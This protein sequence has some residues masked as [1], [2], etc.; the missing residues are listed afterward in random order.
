MARIGNNALLSK[1]LSGE[2]EP[3]LGP[4]PITGWYGTDE[5]SENCCVCCQD[6]WDSLIWGNNR[7]LM[8]DQAIRHICKASVNFR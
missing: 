8:Y 6:L 3:A 2:D 5:Q 7:L 4:K 1:S